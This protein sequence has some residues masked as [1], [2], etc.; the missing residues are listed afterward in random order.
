MSEPDSYDLWL[1]RRMTYGDDL[2]WDC[3]AA[4]STVVTDGGGEATT[5][6]GDCSTKLVVGVDRK[7]T[8]FWRTVWACSCCTMSLIVCWTPASTLLAADVLSRLAPLITDACTVLACEEATV[9]AAP[10]RMSTGWRLTTAVPVRDGS[11]P[12]AD[13]VSFIC[14]T[15]V[16]GPST[17]TVADRGAWLPPTAAV[18]SDTTILP[19]VLSHKLSH[20]LTDILFTANHVLEICWFV[21]FHKC[22]I[23]TNKN[24]WLYMA[25]ACGPVLCCKTLNI[26][27]SFISGADNG[28]S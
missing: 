7:P 1:R 20:E 23:L 16:V 24:T 10:G 5:V 19:T 8:V 2:L 18:T 11:T 15:T 4:V 6:A 21:P 25:M 12:P 26:S 17:F 27:M 3:D 9:M 13:D 22:F 14:F 28:F